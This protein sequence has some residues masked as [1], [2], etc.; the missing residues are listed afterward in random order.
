MKVPPNSM[1]A[2]FSVAYDGT[3]ATNNFLVNAYIT[4]K[5]IRPMS[6]DGMPF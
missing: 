3:E 6:V 5:A 2:I 1:D 4:V